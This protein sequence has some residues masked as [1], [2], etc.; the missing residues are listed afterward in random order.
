MTAGTAGGE[1]GRGEAVEKHQEETK[2]R[3]GRY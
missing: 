3:T 2:C 1:E